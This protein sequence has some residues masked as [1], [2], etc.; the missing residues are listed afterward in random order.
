LDISDEEI[1]IDDLKPRR[2]KK[3]CDLKKLLEFFIIS[4]RSGLYVFWHEFIDALC[5]VSSFF[6]MHFAAQRH[7]EMDT[8]DSWLRT[9]ILVIE[10]S[11][12]A[13]FLMSFIKDY[14]NPLDPKGAPIRNITKIFFNYTRNAFIYDAIALAPVTAFKLYRDRNELLY[15]V[16]II[17]LKRGIENL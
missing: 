4:H 3:G 13:D 11:F 7:D 1:L 15:I 2:K 6:Y 12:L 16:K 5:I 8:V 10:V 17:R 14:E 9:T